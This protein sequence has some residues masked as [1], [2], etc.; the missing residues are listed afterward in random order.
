L[1]GPAVER[2]ILEI[3]A[4]RRAKRPNAA[5]AAWRVDDESL[6]RSKSVNMTV[7]SRVS[8]NAARGRRPSVAHERL[9]PGNTNVR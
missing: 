9:G 6:Q 4:E 3:V 2:G 1:G 8:V 7:T 5:F